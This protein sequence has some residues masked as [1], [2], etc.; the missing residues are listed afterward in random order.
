MQK[1]LALADSKE[2]KLMNET[3]VDTNILVYLIDSEEKRKHEKASQWFNNLQREKK[4]YFIS[5]QNLKEFSAICLKKT[6]LGHEKI[7]EWVEL[8]S[9]IFFP[10]QDS[11]EDILHANEISKKNNIHFWDAMLIAT[12]ERCEIRK[13]LTENTKDFRKYKRIKSENLFA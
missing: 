8:F 12:M 13:I 4:Y 9:R 6:K 3:L 10:I 5:T 2:R 11:K 1:N 7:N